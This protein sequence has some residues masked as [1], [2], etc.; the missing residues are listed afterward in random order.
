MKIAIVYG[1]LTGNTERLAKGVFDRIAPEHEKALFNIKDNPDLSGYDVV[2]FGFWVDKSF[3]F[4]AMKELISETR[5]KEVFLMG[6][7]G[8]FPDSDHGQACIKNTVGLVDKSCNIMG[9]FICNG[10]IDMRLLERIAQMK[11]KNMGE[12][13]FKKHMLDEKNLIKYKMLGEHVN[14]TDIEYCSARFN[15]RVAMKAA[16]DSL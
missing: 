10:K 13:V 16:I 4:K 12:E 9:Y 11:P 8:Y 15:E 2:C 1:S 6:T 3:P 5:N 7:M 14:D